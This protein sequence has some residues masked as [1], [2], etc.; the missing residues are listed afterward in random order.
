MVTCGRKEKRQYKIE[1]G[2]NLGKGRKE[3][4]SVGIK[5]LPEL[6]G[7]SPD[8]PALGLNSCCWFRAL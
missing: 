7:N 2:L 3:K 6:K 1:Y 4:S 5:S 8:R